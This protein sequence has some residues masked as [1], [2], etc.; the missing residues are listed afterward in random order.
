MTGSRQR[1]EIQSCN[2]Y[3]MAYRQRHT[4]SWYDHSVVSDSLRPHG[5]KAPSSM[6][7]SRQESWSR[8]PFPS[9]GTFRPRDRTQVSRIIDRH[10]TIWATREVYDCHMC[11]GIASKLLESKEKHPSLFFCVLIKSFPFRIKFLGCHLPS[12]D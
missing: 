9:P 8:L 5:H 10:F 12:R 1:P 6:G 3:G 7:F 4:P 11:S 2:L